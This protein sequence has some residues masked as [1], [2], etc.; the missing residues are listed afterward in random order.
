[1]SIEKVRSHFS[2]YGM[3]G[4]VLEFSTSS[5]TVE[6][7]AA[8]LAVAPMR[9]AK[10]LSFSTDNGTV[11]LLAAGDA[12]V[13]NRKYRDYF[14]C[15][16]RMLPS[17][18]VERTVGY[19]VGGVCPFDIAPGI[20]VFLDISLRRFFTVFPACGS[21]NSAIE[22]TCDELFRYAQASAW[23][24][25]CKDYADVQDPVLRTDHFILSDLSDNELLLR[26]LGV[27][28]ANEKTGYVPAYQF[29]V[30]LPG[31]DQI[32]VCDLRI[33]YVRGTYFGGNIGYAIDAPYRGHRYAEKAC[34]LLFKLA[35]QHGMPYVII[36]CEENNA[37]SYRTCERL[38][39]KL[40]EIV[41]LPPDTELYR[42]GMRRCRLYRFD[43]LSK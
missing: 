32:G 34:R 12:R 36:S 27:S 21:S 1:M 30:C 26:L 2:K 3:E 39:G 24:D 42:D 23:I 4:R 41:E 15:K 22:L 11:L 5:A 10:T 20:D 37:P 9:I 17:D 38:G 31:G 43:L 19:G 35:A 14:G 18:E 7:A 28:S 16:A 33:G 40:L 8:T 25:V 6:E 29:A 13:D